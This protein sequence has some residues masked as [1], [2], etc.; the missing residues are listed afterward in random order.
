MR[1]DGP[2]AVVDRESLEQA[3]AKGTREFPV[4]V[5][6]VYPDGFV[7]TSG[8][9]PE[10]CNAPAF[11]EALGLPADSPIIPTSRPANAALETLDAAVRLAA[12]RL[13]RT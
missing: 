12:M 6:V 3:R 4:V 8:A 11:R 2:K 10:A 1:S 9:G 7:Q 5:Q 13:A